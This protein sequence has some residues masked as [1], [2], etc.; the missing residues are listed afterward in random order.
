M[1]TWITPLI[2]IVF[3]SILVPGSSFLGHCLC[4]TVGYLFGLKYIT[5][6]APPEKVVKWLEAKLNLLGR[7]PHYVSVEQKTAG[8]YNLLPSTGDD[9][10][11]G[12]SVP[13]NWGMGNS[14]QRLGP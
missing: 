5:F 7:L 9:G 4:V 12:H 1:P 13:L 3:T 14:G 8:R 11:T 2:L 6:L 10:L